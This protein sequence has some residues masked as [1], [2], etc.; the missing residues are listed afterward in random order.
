MHIVFRSVFGSKLYGTDTRT[1]DD[2]YKAIF[3]PSFR[4]LVLNKVN[5]N[6]SINETNKEEKD[7]KSVNG[8]YELEKIPIHKFL[9]LAVECQTMAI[10]M[11]FTPEDKIHS[12]NMRFKDVVLDRKH[13]FLSKN[14]IT[15]VRYCKQQAN[16]YGIKGSRINTVNRYLELLVSKNEDSV[17]YEHVDELKAILDEHSFFVESDKRYESLFNI[18]GKKFLC[19]TKL[20]YIIP[21]LKKFD[22]EYGLRAKMAA[23]NEGVDFKALSHFARAC[24][25]V[26]EIIKTRNLV[27]PLKDRAKILDIKQGIIPYRE[28]APFLEDLLIETEQMLEKS[29][30]PEKPNVNID[31]MLLDLYQI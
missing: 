29:D 11:L 18:C 22:E 14:L 26:Q 12:L 2:D 24:F 8:I 9:K 21:S 7:S 17:L 23:T 30:L 27:F 31:E 28:L 19:S 13:D 25:E 1:S 10:D 20:K 16:K 15:F 6:S 4:E 5:L 3:L